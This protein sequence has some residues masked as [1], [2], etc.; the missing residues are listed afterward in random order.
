L[1]SADATCREEASRLRS[2]VAT[3]EEEKERAI[4]ELESIKQ[5]VHHIEK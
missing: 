3:C 2:K 4:Q 5:Q 1:R